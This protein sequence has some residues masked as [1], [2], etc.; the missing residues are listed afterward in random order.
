MSFSFIFF[1]WEEAL[2]TEMFA[3]YLISTIKHREE[4]YHFEQFLANL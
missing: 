1:G 2:R 3:D 4:I